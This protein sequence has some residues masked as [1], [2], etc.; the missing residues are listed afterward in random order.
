MLFAKV[1]YL[2]LAS[3]EQREQQLPEPPQAA[4]P[5]HSQPCAVETTRMS[6]PENETPPSPAPQSACRKDRQTASKGIVLD[7]ILVEAR[8]KTVACSPAGSG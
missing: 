7:T 4:A 6:S 2:H 8:G 5:P 3:S 1:Q